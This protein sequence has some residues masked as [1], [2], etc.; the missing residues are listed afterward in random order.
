MLAKLLEPYHLKLFISNRLIKVEILN[1]IGNDV[2]TSACTNNRWIVARLKELGGPYASKN[3]DRAAKVIG[4]YIAR[5]SLEK[6]VIPIERL[7][8]SPFRSLDD[9]YI[10]GILTFS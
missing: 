1:K 9:Y 8:T 10:L 6:E 4:E 2:V 7:R 5:K 3:D